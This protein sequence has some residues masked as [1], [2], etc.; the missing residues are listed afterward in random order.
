MSTATRW[1]LAAGFVLVC[2]VTASAALDVPLTLVERANIAR[3]AEPVAAGV[4]LPVGLMDDVGKLT[5]LGPDG[6]PVPCQFTVQTR[7]HP[8]K[9]IKW[10]LL[11]FQ[12]SVPAG[13][14]AVY[15]LTD[16]DKN[17]TPPQPVKVAAQEAPAT[18]PGK[19][20]GAVTITTGA[21]RF[22]I[23]RDKFNL[24]DS[25]A[26]DPAGKGDYAAPLVKPNSADIRLF[27]GGSGLPQ[28]KSFSPAAD[29]DVTLEVEEAGPMR[30]T[31]KLTGKHLSVDD[32]AGDNHLLDFVCR[33]TA[34]AGSGLVKVVYSL[35]CRQGRSIGDGVP[36]D[37]FWFSLPLAID[38]KA[39]TWA[40][41]VGD[42]KALSPA[43]DA[44][45]L[46]AWNDEWEKPKESVVKY[47]KAGYDD[48]CVIAEA[49]DKIVW[50]GD[51][52][53]KRA[54][55]VVRGKY[56]KP[57][58]LTAGW[59][60]VSDDK[61][62]VAAGIRWF[63]QTYPHVIKAE[64]GAG[65]AALL[66]MPHGNMAGRP[67]L[68]T[69]P[70]G[71]RATYYPGMSKTTEV[72]LDFHGPRNVAAITS[73]QVG[74]QAPLRAWA[75]PSWYC[76]QTQAFGRVASSEKTLY[77]DEAFASVQSYDKNLRATLDRIIK[78]RDLQYGEYDSYGMFNFGDT[79]DFIKDQ[80][81]D[82]DDINVTWDNCYYDY[83]HAL[84]LQWARTGDPDYFDLAEQ[85]EH[86]LGDMDMMTWSPQEQFI[87]AA[88]YS[89][90]TM[91]IRMEKGIYQSDTFNHYK[92]GSHFD[93]WY[94]T[95]TKRAFDQ[96]LVSTKF[97]MHPGNNGA[98]GFGEPRSLGNGPIALLNAYRAT[99]EQKYLDRLTFFEKW[100]MAALDKGA[101]IAKGRHWQGG[102]G[103]EG[104][105]E[106]YEQTGDQSAF[107]HLKL[108]AES[109]AA[110]KDYSETT[111]HAF[112][113]LGAQLDK[114]EWSKVAFSRI[115]KTGD[116]KRDWGYGQ[117][118]GNELRSTPY[119]FWYMTKDL[120]KKFEPKK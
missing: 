5:L 79:I 36:L 15:R 29:P 81:G 1:L 101:R 20:I 61:A 69:R 43:T 14:K 59:M 22:V 112:A 73:A 35:E 26:V 113:F 64:L 117:S 27:H 53:R 66:V 57:K 87:G 40:T 51:F 82:P 50:R 96:G 65:G 104:M 77:D 23:K 93:C 28:Y 109:C 99:G 39:A 95:G 94:L 45:D 86:H 60:D 74:L 58:A 16:G 89:D 18:Q 71:A 33:I 13:G 44:K 114:P 30:A 17:P 19:F 37:R 2:C 52:F 72:L 108:Q 46:P 107:D 55:L 100:Y 90:G 31:V 120:P 41:G 7:W 68:L 75:P 11:D 25:V 42:G 9:S 4:P 98:I 115:A 88:R 83:P 47:W 102:I 103:L 80:R 110:M 10:V 116:I 49:S 21:A 32:L 78:H 84:F 63:W 70:H 106:Y 8:G 118:F 97:A 92:N 24:L 119:V 105:R 38:G 111:L 3:V 85:A 12:A 67:P 6:Q 76:E 62:G 91:H 48:A 34:Y 54:D 56:E